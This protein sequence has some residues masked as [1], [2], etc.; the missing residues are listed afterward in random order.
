MS[1]KVL[2]IGATSRERS[3]T[4]AHP[5]AADRWVKGSASASATVR[6]TIDIDRELHRRVRVHCA[7][8]GERMADVVR[9]LLSGRFPE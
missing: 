7:K 6:L 5:V 1:R 2:E 8:S 9:G 3:R 4:A